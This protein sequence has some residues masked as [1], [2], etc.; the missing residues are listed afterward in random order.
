MN[1]SVLGCGRWGSFLAWYQ[2]AV[3]GNNVTLWGEEGHPTYTTLRD[4]GG[5]EYVTLPQSITLTPDLAKA[6]SS[7]EVII[8]SISS[9]ALR[10]FLP[11]VVACGIEGKISCAKYAR[12]NNVPYLGICLGMQTAVVE[13]ARNVLGYKDA[14]SS[15]FDPESAHCVID[16]M[17]DQHGVKMGGTMRLGAYPCKVLGEKMKKAYGKDEISE[18]HRHRYEFN[19]DYRKEVE[20]AGMKIAGTSPS[21]LLVEAVEIPANDFYV[22]VQFHPEFKSRPQ[23]AHPLFREFISAAVKYSRKNR[24]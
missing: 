24:K 3:L 14:N 15:E 19:N 1:V 12:E 18:R 11:R 7:A 8:I 23:S 4:T 2:A 10:S 22:G 16:L 17:P 6:V 5:N 20:S 9:Q 21:G 13:F